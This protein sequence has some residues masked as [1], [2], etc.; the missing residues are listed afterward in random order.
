M[1]KS[2]VQKSGKNIY[3]DFAMPAG[4]DDCN[5]KWEQKSEV[6]KRYNQR[7]ETINLSA[8]GFSELLEEIGELP[9]RK[10]SEIQS[11][12]IGLGCEVLDRDVYEFSKALPVL[13]NTGVKWARLQS[14]W[15]KT[16][17]QDSV[18]DFQ[19]LDN[20]VDP[21]LE[22]GIEPWLSISYGNAIHTPEANPVCGYIR[23]VPLHYG[24]KAVEAWLR[25]V[26]ALAKHYKGRVQYFE[27]WNEPN[28]GFWNMRFG[29][30][31]AQEYVEL[32]RITANAVREEIPDAVM[33]GGAISA[34]YPCNNY[35]RELFEHDIQK[36]ISILTYHPYTKMPEEYNA[37]RIEYIRELME[38]KGC[39]LKLWQGENG[40]M[41]RSTNRAME[42]FKQ[43]VYLA[44]RIITDLIIGF[45]M[46]SFFCL[47]GPAPGSCDM[48]IVDPLRDYAPR[49]AVRTLQ[50]MTR[51][52][53]SK[54]VFRPYSGVE[55]VEPTPFNI[56][57]R[58]YTKELLTGAV[59]AGFVRGDIPLYVYY[60]PE[61]PA[62][63][64]GMH[65]IDLRVW[66]DEERRLEKPVLID[67]V[68][69]KIYRIKLK[70]KEVYDESQGGIHWFFSMPFTLYPMILTD[71]RILKD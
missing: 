63:E 12:P 57:S 50:V 44:R 22:A 18:F 2:K 7:R 16:E 54:T 19:W 26:H 5:K 68:T 8:D 62:L 58:H 60:Y 42:E 45:D 36:Y 10:S 48:G 51:L 35:I 24:K 31:Y 52:F 28:Q 4:Q 40:V 30:Q 49:R 47:A 56:V 67:S 71:E 39:R 53:D 13:R 55:L 6:Y 9:I 29:S 3:K 21:V 59:T 17:K 27:V 46:T 38:K 41:D 11:S 69:G 70:M 1:G 25:Y 14:G 15:N 43:S 20:I 61:N 65:R 34:A 23:N 33:I 32:V 64:F 66:T 37:Q